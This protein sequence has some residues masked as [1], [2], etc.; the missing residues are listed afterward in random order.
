MPSCGSCVCVCSSWASS[1]FDHALRALARRWTCRHSTSHAS[2]TWRASSTTCTRLQ[3]QH[4]THSK[5]KHQ[6]AARTGSG[7]QFRATLAHLHVCASLRATRSRSAARRSSARSS[8]TANARRRAFVS[9]TLRYTVGSLLISVSLL[10]F[11]ACALRLT[12]SVALRCLVHLT[13]AL[14][15]RATCSWSKKSAVRLRHSVPGTIATDARVG[16]SRTTDARP[17]SRSGTLS[18]STPQDA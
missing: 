12:N 16:R 5:Q 8:G 15:V 11:M 13:S 18:R 10:A 3:A 1:S 6:H 7:K 2:K 4:S 17:L 9:W 14:A